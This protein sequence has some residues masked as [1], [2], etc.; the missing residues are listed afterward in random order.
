M[1]SMAGFSVVEEIVECPKPWKSHE[2]VEKRPS[3]F[4]FN[5]PVGDVEDRIQPS[6]LATQQL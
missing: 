4:R 5:V 1:E 3:G 2:A 6:H